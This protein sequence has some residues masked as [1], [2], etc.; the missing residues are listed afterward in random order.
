[1]YGWHSSS[2]LAAHAFILTMHITTKD[3][4]LQLES[5]H[6][7][8][9][10]S[11]TYCLF[12]TN[13]LSRYW[14]RLLNPRKLIDV[15][16]PGLLQGTNTQRAVKF[17]RLPEVKMCCHLQ[18]NTRE[19]KASADF[20][21]VKGLMACRFVVLLL[22]PGDK[23]SWPAPSDQRGSLRNT[24][25]TQATSFQVWPWSHFVLRGSRTLVLFKG[26]CHWHLCCRGKIQCILRSLKYSTLYL[27]FQ[28]FLFLFLLI[29]NKKKQKT[30]LHI[31]LLSS[32]TQRPD[33]TLTGM[34]SFYSVFS[35]V[36]NH[37]VHTGLRTAHLLHVVSTDTDVVDLMGDCLV[38]AKAVSISHWNVPPCV[39]KSFPFQH[40][41]WTEDCW[42][43]CLY[44]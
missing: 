39:I 42:I 36:L 4:L 27:F 14:N 10:L 15:S 22:L 43:F 9:S 28:L 13:G 29:D 17:N 32:L 6:T 38:L 18:D 16:Y 3:A 26:E 8:W 21:S 19:C 44:F 33:G 2:C 41:V 20:T 24:L 11:I 25:T 5:F 35:R 1:M 34:V 30:Y 40:L 31:N 12:Q 23:D 37:P 7:E